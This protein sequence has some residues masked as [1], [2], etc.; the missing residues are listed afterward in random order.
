[1]GRGEGA[2][3]V[4]FLE[5]AEDTDPLDSQAHETCSKFTGQNKGSQD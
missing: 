2:G 4:Y 1:M 3:K 5:K